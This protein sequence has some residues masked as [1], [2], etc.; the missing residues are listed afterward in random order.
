MPIPQPG[1]TED[2]DTF[3]QR[4]MAND[5]MQ[6]YD[7]DQRMA[8]CVNQ[9]NGKASSTEHASKIFVPQVSFKADA[10][11]GTIEVEFAALNKI[12]LDR[13]VTLPGAFGEQ[14]VR[15]QSHGHDTFDF[16][17]GKGTIRESGDKAILSGRLNLNMTRGK[18]A[19]E[20]LKFDMEHGTPLQEWS[21][22][23]DPVDYSFGE[24]EG[25]KVRFLK[26][27]KV[28]SVD[29]VF[30][31]AGIGTR[32]TNV[33]S[34]DLGY[35][36]L[37]DEADGIIKLVIERTKSRLDMRGKEGRT[38]SAANIARLESIAESLGIGHGDLLKMLA[39]L[40]SPKSADVSEELQRERLRFLRIE[41]SRLSGI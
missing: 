33:K 13:D 17:I 23:Y 15:I 18:D 26:Q 20:S 6:E 30:L 37:L 3:L 7:A 9:W 39:E 11:P 16:S 28:Y 12:D 22:I 41:S 5:V 14:Q 40:S 10:P 32:T 19:F 38:L 34:A 25:Q 27:L 8:I 21:Y 1:P 36:D 2:R 29:P 4:C 31:G 35:G 24:F